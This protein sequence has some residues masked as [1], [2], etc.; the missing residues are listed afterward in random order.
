MHCLWTPLLLSVFQTHLSA[1]PSFSISAITNILCLPINFSAIIKPN[2]W[3][4]AVKLTSTYSCLHNWAFL[5]LKL[6]EDQKPL[7]LRDACL[8]PRREPEELTFEN[9]DRL[10]PKPLDPKHGEFLPAV[11]V[12][13]LLERGLRILEYRPAKTEIEGAAVWLWDEVVIAGLFPVT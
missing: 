12:P 3:R 7:F 1:G 2:P 9:D 8:R 13:K 4:S 5:H 6:P 11:L 10:L